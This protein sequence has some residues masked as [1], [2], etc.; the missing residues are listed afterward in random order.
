V[1]AMS[2]EQD[3]SRLAPEYDAFAAQRLA[4][5]GGRAAHVIGALLTFGLWYGLTMILLLF[6]MALGQSDAI[7]ML[8]SQTNWIE[9]TREEDGLAL[10]VCG[11][12]LISLVLLLVANWAVVHLV[13]GR[14]LMTLISSES[15]FRWLKAVQSFLLYAIVIALLS[16]ISS[17][18]F[19]SESI[20]IFDP[21]RYFPFLILVLILTPL[22]ALAEEVFVRGYLFQTV[23]AFTT[24]L[25]LR[26]ILPAV[27]FSALHFAN[28]D[29]QQGGGWA[30][31]TYFVFGI[32]FGWLTIKSGG[33]ELATGA[34]TANNILAFSVASSAGA[35]MPFATLYYDPEP[36]Y[37]V[38]LGVLIL[39]AA[40]HYL[41][42]FKVFRS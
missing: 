40:L 10:V 11:T 28:A 36:N 29:M 14:G 3:P 39:A 21:A 4:G 19:P 42:I 18:F 34:H 27:L 20:F 8:E 12:I 33:V 7:V 6:V 37:A 9:L 31:A 38:G 24:R 5:R 41:L 17:V 25:T 23:S 16:S 1:R 22:Q 30:M 26:L 35:G 2:D 13:H 32:Y 15:R